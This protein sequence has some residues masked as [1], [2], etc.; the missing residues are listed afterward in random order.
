MSEAIGLF[1]VNALF[2]LLVIWL[3]DRF[4]GRNIGTLGARGSNC[5]GH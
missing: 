5:G 2:V 4:S 3:Y 1:L